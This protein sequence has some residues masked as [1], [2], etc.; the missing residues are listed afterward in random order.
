MVRLFVSL[1]Q[2]HICN[3]WFSALHQVEWDNFSLRQ[4]KNEDKMFSN[5]FCTFVLLWYIYN[6]ILH[7]ILYGV[8]NKTNQIFQLQ[9]HSVQRMMCS[10]AAKI[11]HS[12]D[13]TFNPLPPRGLPFRSVWKRQPLPTQCSQFAWESG[14]L[15]FCSC[16]LGALSKYQNQIKKIGLSKSKRS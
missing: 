13:I 10:S 8:D 3:R 14:Y 16:Q 5:S 11:R 4:Q 12:C 9:K 15:P 1:Q 6:S 2:T 7:E